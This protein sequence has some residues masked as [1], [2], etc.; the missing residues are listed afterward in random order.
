[1]KVI[2]MKSPNN[3]RD[4]TPLGHLL[5][6]N[7]TFNFGTR[8]QPIEQLSEIVPWESSNSSGFQDHRLLY[9]Q[10]QQDSIAKDNTHTTPST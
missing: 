10:R 2:L 9:T 3:E 4:R 5:S 1:M 6:S 8:F 7:E